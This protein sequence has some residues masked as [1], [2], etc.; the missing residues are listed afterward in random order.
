[1][2][3]K[4]S[5]SFKLTKELHVTGQLHKKINTRLFMMAAMVLIGF[6]V[7]VYDIVIGRI[8]FVMALIYG[9]IATISGLLMSKTNKMDWD[10][11]KEL[12]VAGKMDW[13]SGIILA[14]YMLVRLGSRFYLNNFYHNAVTV[15]AI[16]MAIMAGFALGKFIGLTLTVRRTYLNKD[17][18]N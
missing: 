9:S 6:G 14:V 17:N 13:T 2:F 1:M 3:N 4:I 7:I 18:E 12:I 10:E 16:S 8:G 5:D 11:E 15:L